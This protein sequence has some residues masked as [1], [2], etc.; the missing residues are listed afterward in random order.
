MIEKKE[1][2]YTVFTKCYTYNHS[3]YIEDTL[4][5]F[6]IQETSFPVVF[7][8]ADDASTDGE[9]DILR[10]WAKNNLYLNEEGV[11]YFKETE[12]GE[13]F[14]ARHK[15]RHNLYFAILLFRENQHSLK[16]PKWPHIMQWYEKSKYRAYCEG[17]DYWTDPLKLQKQ[18][19]FLESHNNVSLCFHPVKVL[20]E[21]IKVNLQNKPGYSSIKDL[22]FGNYIATG[23]VVCRNDDRIEA[24][25]EMKIKRS[26]VGDYQA[27]MFYAL[28]G[29]LYSFNNIM[30]VY[31]LHSDYS[32]RG[33]SVYEKKRDCEGYLY[34]LIHIEDMPLFP[35]LILKIRYLING[36]VIGQLEESKEKINLETLNDN[37]GER[38][39]LKKASKAILSSIFTVLKV[40]ESL[41]YKII[42]LVK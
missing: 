28:I 3:R 14:Y 36:L 21:D 19:D 9:P 22:C 33:T 42:N 18:V 27:F 31:R 4:R 24:Y 39:F 6:S 17:D 5:G 23:S 35:K 38:F 25:N 11:A 12:Y 41:N 2:K 32:W 34:N 30:G 16:K 7:T 15:E 8:I 37:K 13:L 26:K 29:D 1:Y 20:G 10:N 40:I